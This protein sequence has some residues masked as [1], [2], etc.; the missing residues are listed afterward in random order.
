MQIAGNVVA[1]YDFRTIPKD[2]SKLIATAPIWLDDVNA[3]GTANS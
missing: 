1:G 2:P 3:R